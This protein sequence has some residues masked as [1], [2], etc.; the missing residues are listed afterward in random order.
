[1]ERPGPE[2]DTVEETASDLHALL[3]ASGE[4]GPY[5]LVGA[6]ITGIYI[7]AYQRYFL[8]TWPA[9]FLRL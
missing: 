8:R 6:S 4:H 5:V 9:L 1:V 3:Q 7:Q 2:E